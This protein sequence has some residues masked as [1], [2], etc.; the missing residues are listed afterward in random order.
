MSWTDWLLVASLL[1]NGLF[2]FVHV[3]IGWPHRAD[4]TTDWTKIFRGSYFAIAFAW[5]EVVALMLAVLAVGNPLGVWLG[6]IGLVAFTGQVAMMWTSDPTAA[7]LML[8]HV[9]V[10][11]VW[12]VAN[13]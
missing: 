2:A 12:I 5:L 11:V 7:R 3:A 10:L 13:L 9:G 8:I 6:V 4:A 1:L